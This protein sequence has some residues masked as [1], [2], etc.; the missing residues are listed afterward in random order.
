MN[1]ITYGVKVNGREFKECDNIKEAEKL[2][3]ELTNRRTG[4]TTKMFLTGIINE[5][6]IPNI[7][8]VFKNCSMAK[9]ASYSFI[10]ILKKLNIPYTYRGLDNSV[11]VSST[12]YEFISNSMYIEK[13]KYI[14]KDCTVV[15]KDHSCGE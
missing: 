11:I 4:R 13:C 6:F 7:V 9:N 3:N 8:F 10:D 1:K 2:G 14:R 5:D 15:F 12:L